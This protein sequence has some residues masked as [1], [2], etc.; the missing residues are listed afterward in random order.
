MKAAC[1]S[2]CGGNQEHSRP[3]MGVAMVLP[4]REKGEASLRELRMCVFLVFDVCSDG[5]QRGCLQVASGF[6]LPVG[7]LSPAG[8]QPDS[9]TFL[10]KIQP[11]GLLLSSW[12]QGVE[13]GVPE[14]VL[15]VSTASVARQVQRCL[16][17]SSQLWLNRA[18]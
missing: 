6:F 13:K 2:V 12:P 17:L 4:L 3:L 7:P 1:T 15:S 14:D 10:L 9:I 18:C 11:E 16:P 5:G 8:P